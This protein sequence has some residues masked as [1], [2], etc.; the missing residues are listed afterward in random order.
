MGLGSRRASPRGRRAAG[1][2]ETDATFV[3]ASRRPRLPDGQR[4]QPALR[5]RGQDRRGTCGAT[6]RRSTGCPSCA[7]RARSTVRRAGSP[8]RSAPIGKPLGLVIGGDMTDDGGGQVMLPGEGTQLLQFSHRYQEGA[9]PTASTFQ[10]MPASAITTSTRTGRRRMSTGTA[11][12]CATMS[13][14]TT[15]RAWSSARRCRP[16]ITTSILTTI[17]GTGA[18]CTSSSC[19]ASAATATRARRAACRG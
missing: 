15:G 14:S 11:A 12:S 2:A 17:P 6:L 7:G 5:G 4:A 8:R 16:A 18:A 9:V 19:T 1:Q 13:S 10:S 3:F